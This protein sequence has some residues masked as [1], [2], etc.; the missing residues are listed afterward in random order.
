[1]NA[2]G[3]VAAV[4]TVYG[5]L[6]S[7]SETRKATPTN[8]SLAAARRAF[9]YDFG[10]A[11]ND[12]QIVRVTPETW[13]DA[14]LGVPDPNYVYTQQQIPG[15]RVEVAAMGR[16]AEYHCDAHGRCRLCPPCTARLSGG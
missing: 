1:M 10:A 5:F 16:I 12:V 9:A 11:E 7:R 13:A 14:S 2:W 4:I 6:H 8:A 15:Y 3:V